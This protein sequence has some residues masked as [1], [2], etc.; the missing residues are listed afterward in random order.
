[1]MKRYFI[2][3]AYILTALLLAFGCAKQTAHEADRT[4]R[5]YY[6]DEDHGS[7]LVMERTLLSET[8][9]DRVDELLKALQFDPMINHMTAALDEGIEIKSRTISGNGLKIDLSV[10][11]NSLSKTEEVL[12]RAAVVETL[13]QLDGIDHVEFFVEGEDL[14]DDHGKPYGP[15]RGDS[16]I[17]DTATEINTYDRRR[18]TLYFADMEGYHLKKTTRTV[19]YSANLS[20]EK[21]IVQKLIEGPE[22][23]E[24]VYPTIPRDA[25]LLSVTTNNGVC[26]VNFNAAIREKPYNAAE[27][28]VIYSIVD[29][30]TEL[31]NISQVQILI[32]G[33]PDGTLY[34]SMSLDRL[35]ERETDIVQ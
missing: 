6:P 29:S 28:V 4:V 20:A 7:L 16:F 1:M 34:G 19:V 15:M 2:I 10:S 23:G 31:P 13:T 9:E 35:Y 8:L 11:Y 26:Y 12:T 17:N 30:L 18:I 25:Q 21:L 27:N 33:V 3:I 32:E 22:T 14:E 5:V 24:D